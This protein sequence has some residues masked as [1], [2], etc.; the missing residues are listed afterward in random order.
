MAT[1][2][3]KAFLLPDAPLSMS[4]YHAMIG[5]ENVAHFRIHDCHY[6]VHLWNDLNNP[7]EI[8]ECITKFRC[9]ASAASEFADFIEKNY[10]HSKPNSHEP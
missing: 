6:G 3:K 2:S 8:L 7:E 1:Y 9:L 10:K 5:I 4:A